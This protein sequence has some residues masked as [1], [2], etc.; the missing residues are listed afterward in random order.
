MINTVS[1]LIK[2]KSSHMTY[3][4]Y[5][6]LLIYSVS[7]DVYKKKELYSMSIYKYS[8]RMI[9][10]VQMWIMFSVTCLHAMFNRIFYYRFFFT[11][12]GKKSLDQMFMGS[13]IIVWRKYLDF[14]TY[15]VLSRCTIDIYQS[16]NVQY[17]WYI[18][19]AT[20]LRGWSNNLV[21]WI[22]IFKR[23]IT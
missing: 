11:M 17:I 1:Y 22:T 2:L 4:A 13:R 6:L 16:Q 21:H 23:S 7:L 8:S 3:I 9:W 19:N 20:F 18:L 15:Y 10:Q 12:A 5:I 14:R